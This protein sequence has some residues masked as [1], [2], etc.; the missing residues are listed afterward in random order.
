MFTLAWK[1]DGPG[2]VQRRRRDGHADHDGDHVTCVSHWDRR[3]IT[4][5]AATWNVLREAVYRP[6]AGERIELIPHLDKFW[7]TWS[8]LPPGH[9]ALSE[10][11]IRPD[12]ARWQR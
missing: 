4:T 7:L 11:D 12:R 3:A 6:L 8:S 10:Q 1:S 2:R 5:A 9:R